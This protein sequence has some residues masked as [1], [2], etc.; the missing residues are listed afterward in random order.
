MT[1]AFI[2]TENFIRASSRGFAGAAPMFPSAVE[3]VQT[4]RWRQPVPMQT[5]LFAAI[6]WKKKETFHPILLKKD[7]SKA[8]STKNVTSCL[9]SRL[10]TK[11]ICSNSI[12][13]SMPFYILG[14]NKKKGE[15]ILF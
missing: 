3:D 15:I 9:Q 12:Q 7:G 8:D 1:V 10:L 4:C 11:F 2:E 6:D 13:S 14:I 5:I